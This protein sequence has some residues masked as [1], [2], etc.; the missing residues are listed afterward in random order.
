MIV[1]Y[2]QMPERGI[3]PRQ[4]RQGEQGC[5]QADANQQKLFPFGPELP[6]PSIYATRTIVIR[7]IGHLANLSLILIKM[8]NRVTDRSFPCHRSGDGAAF[9]LPRRFCTVTAL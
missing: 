8:V 9:R 4:G 6:K 3:M 7:L 2:I 5:R 1:S